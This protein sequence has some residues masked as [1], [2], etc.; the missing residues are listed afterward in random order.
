MRRVRRA[1]ACR[2]GM[3]RVRRV[4]RAKPYLLFSKYSQHPSIRSCVIENQQI[5][6]SPPHPPLAPLMTP[7]IPVPT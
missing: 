7:I 3:R 4:R 5:R 6:F 1:N 2:D